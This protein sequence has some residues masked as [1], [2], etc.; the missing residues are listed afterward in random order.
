MSGRLER[1]SHG[2]LRDFGVVNTCI[3]GSHIRFIPLGL[4]V[5]ICGREMGIKIIEGDKVFSNEKGGRQ[6]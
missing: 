4:Q 6:V 5:V 2:K 1:C 3:D